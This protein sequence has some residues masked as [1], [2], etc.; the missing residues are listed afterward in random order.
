M[1]A[2]DGTIALIE[3]LKAEN[4][5]LEQENRRLKTK[6]DIITKNIKEEL[7]LTRDAIITNGFNTDNR[8]YARHVAFQEVLDIMHEEL[9]N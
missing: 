9:G 4:D 2:I 7:T 1:S 8:L 3:E 6:I 5:L